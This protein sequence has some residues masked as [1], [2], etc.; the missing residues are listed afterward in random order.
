MLVG[1]ARVST[2]REQDLAPQLN[3]LHGAGCKR[4]FEEK[5]S[6]AQRER[7]ALEA[8][9]ECMRAVDTLMVWRL[10]RLAR[11][12]KQLIETVEGFGECGAGLRSLTEA[13]D[14]TTAGGKLVFRRIGTS[15]PTSGS[16]LNV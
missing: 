3:A 12:L 13:I 16:W 7:P 4:V 2:Q 1:H 14:T 11:S 9:L 6:G 5:A 8:A 10:D 15:T